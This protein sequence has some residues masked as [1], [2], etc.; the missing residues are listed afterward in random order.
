MINGDFNIEEAQS[1]IH[2][3]DEQGP[4]TAEAIADPKPTDMKGSLQH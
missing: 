1:Q 3:V 2:L 4:S